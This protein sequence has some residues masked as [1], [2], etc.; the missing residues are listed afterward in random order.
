MENIFF[1]VGDLVR[2]I[3]GV[4]VE[5][6]E[7]HHDGWLVVDADGHEKFLEKLQGSLG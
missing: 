6:L 1:K 5:I 3:D 4:E 7:M 2:T